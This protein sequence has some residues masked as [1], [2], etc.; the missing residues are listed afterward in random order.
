M[1]IFARLLGVFLI[2][3]V[4]T[5]PVPA[6]TNPM[7]F[8][9]KAG[10]MDADISG[11]DAAINLGA[12]AGYDLFT[13]P[14]GTWSIEGELTTTASDGDVTGGGEWDADTLA[15]YG[16]FRTVGEKYLKARAGFFSQDIK[17]AGGSAGTLSG[18]DD[19]GYAF[20][21]AGGVNMTS[22]SSLELAYTAGTEDLSFLSLDYVFRF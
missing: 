21:V 2:S 7:Y 1:K 17:R 4:V 12:A 18:A 5:S 15:L 6:K 8:S 19:R 20:G 11:F 22:T 16:V 14:M 3:V 13:G 9:V 10:L